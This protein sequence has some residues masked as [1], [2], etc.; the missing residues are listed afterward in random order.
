MIQPL[1]VG[2]IFLG[3]S[4]CLGMYLKNYFM[5]RAEKLNQEYDVFCTIEKDRL[6]KKSRTIWYRPDDTAVDLKSGRYLLNG[7]YYEEETSHKLYDLRSSE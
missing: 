1:C 4:F 5:G 7:R 2:F 6:K 3:G